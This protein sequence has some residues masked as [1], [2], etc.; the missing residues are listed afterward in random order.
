M[1]SS[2]GLTPSTLIIF[3]KSSIPEKDI[4]PIAFSFPSTVDFIFPDPSPICASLVNSEA[5]NPTISSNAP[6]VPEPSSLD[7]TT[8]GASFPPTSF[9]L[10]IFPV[11]ISFFR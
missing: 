1:F 8:I 10:V 6:L 7:T 9:Q 4:Y 2:V 5:S 11:Y 3:T